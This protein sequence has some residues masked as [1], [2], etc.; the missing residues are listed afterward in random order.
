MTKEFYRTAFFMWAALLCT[1]MLVEAAADQPMVTAA[2]SAT[3]A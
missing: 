3:L 2:R 1:T